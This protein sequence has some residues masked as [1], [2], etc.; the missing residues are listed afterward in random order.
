MDLGTAGSISATRTAGPREHG[1]ASFVP[2]LPASWGGGGDIAWEFQA[3]KREDSNPTTTSTCL[4]TANLWSRA[5]CPG[6]TAAPPEDAPAQ[7]P[8]LGSGCWNLGVR[9][10]P[11]SPP[12]SRT[13]PGTGEVGSSQSFPHCRPAHLG[14]GVPTTL[15]V[16]STMEV[17]VSPPKIREL[18]FL[19]SVSG[20]EREV[21]GI[22]ESQHNRGQLRG[23]AN[24]NYYR[25][26]HSHK[27][28]YNIH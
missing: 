17:P 15:E 28:R 18:R 1:W 8:F 7:G 12:G 11:P 20:G 19:Q 13:A 23:M 4:V 14:A 24:K 6:A 3:E 9:A 22:T 27:A 16:S 2:G 21:G 5:E 25:P 10:P 26:L